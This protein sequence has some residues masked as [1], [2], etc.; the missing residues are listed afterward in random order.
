[1]MIVSEAATL[2]RIEPF[3]SWN[4]PIAWTGFILFAD[5]SSCAGCGDRSWIRSAPGE[6][7]FL[8]LAVDSAL[9]RLRVLQP[10]HR[11]LALRRPS[12]ESWLA[13]FGYAW[14]FATIWPAIFEGGRSD[15]A[16]VREPD[17]AGSRA[18]HAGPVSTSRCEAAHRGLGAERRSVAARS[19]PSR[20]LAAP[21]WLGFIFLLDP[22][23]A[24]LGG[25][26]LI[27][28]SGAAGR[29]RWST[30]AQRLPLRRALG[31]LEL[32][33]ARKMALHVPIMER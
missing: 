22:I 4:T 25:E 18:R 28:D 5:G 2:A 20:Y 3:W 17:L 13:Y 11:Q 16:S 21:V 14:S 19:G 26:S 10:L 29:P 6:F 7:V 1:M 9:A 32:L 12:R 8:A 31:I 24:R 30:C 33:V 15:A 23:N 27:A